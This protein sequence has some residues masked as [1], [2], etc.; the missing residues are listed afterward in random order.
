MLEA[1]GLGKDDEVTPEFH[2]M[3]E[4]AG[5]WR[6]VAE[7][8]KYEISSLGQ[9]RRV[10]YRGITKLLK[11]SE[12]KSGYVRVTFYAGDGRLVQRY[13]HRLVCA[14][15]CGE[16]TPERNQACHRDGNKGNNTDKNLYWGTPKD[17]AADSIRHGTHPVCKFGGPVRSR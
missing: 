4:A 11:C 16:P 9:V 5:I 17:N 6:A 13:I 2:T 12:T 8:P 7:F 15:F 14:A 3:I 1:R 10:D